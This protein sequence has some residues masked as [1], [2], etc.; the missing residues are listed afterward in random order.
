VGFAAGQGLFQPQRITR[1]THWPPGPAEPVPIPAVCCV[2]QPKGGLLVLAGYNGGLLRST[3][4][5]LTWQADPLVS[6]APVV[7]ALAATRTPERGE[8]YA[9]TAQDGIFVS[10]DGGG[11]W[12]RWNFGLLDWH[13]YSLAAAKRAGGSRVILAGTE[14]G[15]FYSENAGRA[16]RETDFPIDAGTVLALTTSDEGDLAFAGA[17]SGALFR[18]LDAGRSWAR[19]YPRP[20]RVEEGQFEGEISALVQSGSNCGWPA[21]RVGASE[22]RRRLARVEPAAASRPHPSLALDEAHPDGLPAGSLKG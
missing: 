11:R 14:T 19:V 3:D 20:A 5:G 13:V 16:W 21:D 10:Q 9:G 17:E 18:S 6:P 2:T 12:V 8:L 1:K 7:T 22:R 4:S 15:V